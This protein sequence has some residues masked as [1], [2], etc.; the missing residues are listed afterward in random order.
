MEKTANLTWLKY[1]RAV[2]R[3]QHVTQAAL[4]LGL[5]QPALSRAISALESEIGIPLFERSGRS[6]SLTPDGKVF[7][8]YV[9]R[10]FRVIEDGYEELGDRNA[11]GRGSVS[12]G[13]LRS[14]SH[15]FIPQLVSRFRAAHPDVQISFFQSNS[16]GLEDEMKRGRLDLIFVARIRDTG[17]FTWVELGSQEIHLVVPLTH[18]IATQEAVSLAEVKDEPFISFRPGHAFRILGDGVFASAGLTPKIA[19]ECDDGSYLMTLVAAGLGIALVP[20]DYITP[21]GFKIVRLASPHARRTIGIAWQ[22]GRYLNKSAQ[23]FL[24]LART[25]VGADMKF[26]PA[27]PAR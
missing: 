21:D 25:A 6:L 12:I 13:F 7:L 15:T 8:D 24:D 18:P 27:E 3:T 26:A 1:F 22:N 23:A 17:S 19:F 10:A 9:E 20:P 5:S 14:L 4:Q 16:H 11:L 2:G